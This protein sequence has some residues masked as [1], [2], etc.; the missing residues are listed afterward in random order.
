MPEKCVPC[1]ALNLLNSRLCLFC[2]THRLPVTTESF[3]TENRIF[4]M[5]SLMDPGTA[6]GSN[7]TPSK[8]RALEETLDETR[9]NRSGIDVTMVN[10]TKKAKMDSVV[11]PPL[12]TETTGRFSRED[13]DHE[14]SDIEGEEEKE[15][16]KDSPSKPTERKPKGR[17]AV[18]PKNI[19]EI[20][21][22]WNSIH[23]LAKDN[24]DY[25]TLDVW[26]LVE[27]NGLRHRIRA[28]WDANRCTVPTKRGKTGQNVAK[29]PDDFDEMVETYNREVGP[30][31]GKVDATEW[32]SSS[33]NRKR[34]LVLGWW[35]RHKVGLEPKGPVP[36]DAPDGLI[37]WYNHKYM[38]SKELQFEELTEDIWKF[39]TPH[40]RTVLKQKY[41]RYLGGLNYVVKYRVDRANR[42][43]RHERQKSGPQ[44]DEIQNC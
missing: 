21:D 29:K 8:K 44:D 4:S 2:K 15:R 16:E 32:D 31:K 35:N 11:D 25:V 39:K 26:K 30:R 24:P 34:K 1:A 42:L 17:L 10:S 18:I 28:S 7:K 20:L 38:P 43:E 5:T 14:A 13:S 23:G 9:D 40:E 36:H 37:G 19:V 41:E 12:D 33:Y 27:S 22:A 3:I 6:V